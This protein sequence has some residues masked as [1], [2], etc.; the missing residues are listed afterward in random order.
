M[1]DH[2]LHQ[3]DKSWHE[4]NKCED[5]ESQG[6]V[7]EDFADNIAVQDAHGANAECSTVAGLERERRGR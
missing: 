2:Q 4:Q 1:T 7:A 6:G 5:D 3:A